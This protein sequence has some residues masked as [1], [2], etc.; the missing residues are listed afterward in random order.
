MPAGYAVPVRLT[1]KQERYCRR[2]IGITR[3]IYNLCV[4]THR[5]CR[6]NRMPWPS[7]QDIY[8]AFNACKR[9]DYPFV[10]EVA[11]RVQEGAFMD[12]GASIT[13]ASARTTRSSPRS[14]AGCRKERSWTSARRSRTG[15]IQTILLGHHGSERGAGRCRNG[16]DQVPAGL[17]GPVASLQGVACRPILSIEQDLLCLWG[18]ER[19]TQA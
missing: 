15:A 9:E 14:P 3:F 8:K 18:R 5:F 10:T 16:L 12:F 7:W 13:P 19:E 2:A 11:S 1:V 6:T 4:A 17:Q